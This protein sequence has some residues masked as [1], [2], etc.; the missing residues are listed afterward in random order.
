MNSVDTQKPSRSSVCDVCNGHGFLDTE[1][2]CPTPSDGFFDATECYAC[3]KSD[4]CEICGTLED[5]GVFTVL[6]KFNFDIC[7]RCY[8]DKQKLMAWFRAEF[9]QAIQEETAR[10]HQGAAN[11]IPN[12][13][14]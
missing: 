9:E 5:V 14:R 1:T 11:E 2:G 10:L 4:E 3:A 13:Q 12:L 6:D 7:R 8:N